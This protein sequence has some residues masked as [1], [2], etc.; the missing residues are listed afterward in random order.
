MSRS[1]VREEKGGLKMII[2]MQMSNVTKEMMEAMEEAM[3]IKEA[4]V[5]KAADALPDALSYE[6]LKFAY[7]EA[8]TKT[9]HFVEEILQLIDAWNEARRSEAMLRKIEKQ[10]ERQQEA[11]NESENAVGREA[12]YTDKAI[13][14]GKEKDEEIKKLKEKA[15]R[16]TEENEAAVAFIEKQASAQVELEQKLEELEKRQ[17]IKGLGWISVKDG[18]PKEEGNYLVFIHGAKRSA[19][20]CWDG[21]KFLPLAPL[22]SLISFGGPVELWKPMP[23]REIKD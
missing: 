14:Y 8:N 2:H 16:L 15:A 6:A 21:E 11:L 7:I 23:G 22:G 1:D 4:E 20:A 13:D 12:N 18:T 5:L 19:C 9:K 10:A 3:G 17:R